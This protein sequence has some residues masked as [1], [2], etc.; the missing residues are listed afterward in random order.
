MN[1]INFKE[2]PFYIK[3]TFKLLMILLLGL[4]L[5]QGQGI[6][7]P[8]IFSILLSILLLP[9]VNFLVN[10]LLFPKPIAVLT[11]VILSLAVIGTVIY[12]FSHQIAGFLKDIPSIRDHL[13]VHY[14]TLQTW[15]QTR[16]HISSEQ[17][18]VML[19][20]ATNNVKSSGSEVIGQTFFTITH[21]LFFIIMIAI[22][23][24]LILVY[25]HMIRQF[26]IEVFNKDHEEQVKE[27]LLESKG[28]VQKYMVG[29]I[30]EMGIIAILNTSVLLFLGIKYAI[31]LG[32]LTAIL[33]IIPYIGI[34]SGMIFTA[35]ITLTTSTH[36]SDIAW[37]VICFEVIHFFDANF[38]MPRIVG[39]KVKINALITILGVVIGGTLLGLA[40]IFLALPSIAILKII[41]DRIEDLK[42]WG[43]LMGGDTTAEKGRIARRLEKIKLKKQKKVAS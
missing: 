2:L 3:F 25:K 17:Q 35:L 33:N 40:G 15:V 6:I 34:I 26:I 28:I 23:T 37:I 29:L 11:A 18:S 43:K 19:D 30:T 24:F 16:F 41:F 12:F 5:I 21:T 32:I 36:L 7:V 10:K 42:P 14:Q 13:Q 38:L 9:V 1:Q 31:F 39:S 4:L 20:R 22:Y 27:V 8:L